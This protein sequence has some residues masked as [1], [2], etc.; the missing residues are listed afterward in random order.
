MQT[1]RLEYLFRRHLEKIATPEEKTE[2]LELIQND[3]YNDQLNMLVGKALEAEHTGNSLSDDTAAS[4]LASITHTDQSERNTHQNVPVIK[5][6]R[7]LF[8]KKIA[9]AAAAVV[10]GIMVG[11]IY[12][13]NIPTHRGES[14][15]MA[16]DPKIND[17]VPGNYRA[18][19]TLANGSQIVLD[20][21]GKQVFNQGNVVISQQKGRLQ[22]K[23]TQSSA[24]LMYNTLTTPRGA[25]YHIALPDG[26]QVWLNAAS[27]L[28]YPVVFSGTGRRVELTG[29]GYFEVAKNPIK[30]FYVKVGDMEVKVL[31]THFNVMAYPDEAAIRTTLLEGSVTVADR[32]ASV[33]H[34][35]PGQQA[36]LTNKNLS[37]SNNAD[38]EEVIAWKN[39]SFLFNGTDLPV[40]LRQFARWYNIDVIYQGQKKNY[41]FTGKIP[42]S[43]HLS[44][45]L[46]LFQVNDI[47]YTFQ[48]NQLIVQP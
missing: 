10:I 1:N 37:V 47:P 17:A 31:G 11:G 44:S 23:A 5:R 9:Y 48:N 32:G 40:L 13:W 42:R 36:Q 12:W 14:R 4:I 7:N 24:T 2:L 46:K 6:R 19:L 35:S 22:Y 45:V 16:V 25:Q 34:L 43:A 38:L 29:E 18:I 26:T 21:A 8:V 28:K 27:S 15:P 20:S 41:A 3:A 39:G 30:P 33:V